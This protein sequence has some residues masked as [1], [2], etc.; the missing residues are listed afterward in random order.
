M[1]GKRTRTQRQQHQQPGG[2]ASVCLPPPRPFRRPMEGGQLTLSLRRLL[3]LRRPSDAASGMDKRR[4]T[5]SPQRTMKISKRR[6]AKRTKRAQ[7]RRRTTMDRLTASR[8]HR[9]RQRQLQWFN[10]P[11]L[12]S[13]A[14][15]D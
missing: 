9:L 6:A 12:S 7:K 15:R 13:L 4:S 10:C 11:Q 14:F 2:H 5:D 3:F 1:S 8:P